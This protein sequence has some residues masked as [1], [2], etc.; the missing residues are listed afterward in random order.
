MLRR[1]LL[2]CLSLV[3]MTLTAGAPSLVVPVAELPTPAPPAI[4]STGD[5]A[6]PAPVS[7]A[8]PAPIRLLIPRIAVDASIEALG[9]DQN[10]ALAIPAD[11]KD[12]AWFDQGPKP[13]QPGNAL[14]NG[15]VS[16]WTGSA[17][18]ARLAELRPGDRVLVVRGDGTRASFKVTGL[19]SLP[20]G[21]RDISLFAASQTATVTLITCS[22]WWNAGLGSYTQRL[23]VSATLE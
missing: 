20:A 5:S 19:R 6:P 18:F 8:D 12:V 4:A 17:V 11:A 21:A 15:H 13:G 16:W 23:L 14:I 10:R 9:L 3:A 2:L 1:T 7:V 22:G